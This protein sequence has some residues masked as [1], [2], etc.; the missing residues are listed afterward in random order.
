MAAASGPPPVCPNRRRLAGPVPRSA[1][2]RRG[3]RS[4]RDPN[5][6][7]EA[8]MSVT[9]EGAPS[10]ARFTSTMP[11]A[12]R[13]RAAIRVGPTGSPS[14]RAPASTPNSGVRKVKACSVVAR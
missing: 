13:A 3:R 8:S 4:A 9:I 6:E 14:S 11:M 2:R 7:S 12:I 5:P 10:Q 1:V